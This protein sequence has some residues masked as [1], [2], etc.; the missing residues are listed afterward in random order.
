MIDIVP[1]A[2]CQHTETAGH[3]WVR[4]FVQA[5]PRS[6]SRRKAGPR[7]GGVRLAPDFLKLVGL[8][9]QAHLDLPVSA[10]GDGFRPSAVR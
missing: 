9:C 6:Q 2:L 7:G 1:A 3:C 8:V 10:L 5:P 4:M